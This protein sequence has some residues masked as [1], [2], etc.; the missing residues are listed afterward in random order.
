MLDAAGEAGLQRLA[1]WP[2]WKPCCVPGPSPK[3]ALE[4]FIKISRRLCFPKWLKTIRSKL[5]S[6]KIYSLMTLILE[7]TCTN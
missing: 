3:N 4:G 6:E 2:A 1:R 5:K 7:N